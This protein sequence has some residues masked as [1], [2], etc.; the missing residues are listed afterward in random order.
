MKDI[1]H[2]V[3]DVGQVLLHWDPE[4][5]YRDLIPDDEARTYFLTNVCTPEWN[6]EQDRGRD[7][8]VAEEQL[9]TKFPDHEPMIKAFR[10]N[11]HNSISHAYDDVVHI[12]NGL[13]ENSH[14]VTILSNFNQH[15]FVECAERFPFL[16]NPRGATVSG[17]VG[18][19]KPDIDIYRHH[20]REFGL[21]PQKTL[22]LDDSLANVEAAQKCGWRAVQFF[23][24]EGPHRLQQILADVGISID[25][26]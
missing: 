26:E 21:N 23:G 7:W 15:T 12:M 20:I 16:L 10:Q 5:I 6:I 2:I 18:L 1:E 13:I 3:F 19:I 14:D 9:I 22:F 8:S 4:L 24:R 11:W 17:N 25:I